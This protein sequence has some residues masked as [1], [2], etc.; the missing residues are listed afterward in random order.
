MQQP[1]FYVLLCVEVLLV[2]GSPF[3][4]VQFS[5]PDASV[6]P[7]GNAARSVSE[8]L[9]TEFGRNQT[10][11]ITIG[12]SMNGDATSEQNLARLT[13]YS[14]RLKAVPGVTSVASAAALPKD[15]AALSGYARNRN[16][17]VDVYFAPDAQSAAAQKLVERVRDEKP[18]AEST[19][20]VGGETAKLVDLVQG[21]NAA[22]LPMFGVILAVISVLLFAAFGSVVLSLKA[23]AMNTLSLG[24]S[25]G[26][27][28]WIFQEGHLAWLVGARASGAIDA[29]QPVLMLAVVFGLSMDYEV[30]LLSRV[31]EAYV[32]T[33]DTTKAVAIGMQQ[34]GPII[35]RAALLM[36]VVVG[37]FSTSN[38]AL[39]KMV[40]VGMAVAIAVDATVVRA[41]L[42]PALM[43]MMGRA[44]WWAPHPLH[45]LHLLI[46]PEPTPV[47]TRR[48]RIAVSTRHEHLHPKPIPRSRPRSHPP[49]KQTQS[50]QTVAS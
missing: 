18:P 10:K 24:A 28:V 7:A 8:T 46:T 34:T 49:R 14:A 6:L 19:V 25:F 5:R 26:A 11:P 44:N 29:T 41:L 4:H 1:A 22:L 33:H 40:G 35:T 42:V 16:A 2:M 39:L 12:V 45:A 38:I 23:V 32:R 20:V 31:K 37:A 27:V 50:N 21:R 48:P 43:R 30:F 13:A 9:D 3:L 15:S 36:I 47:V 17:R